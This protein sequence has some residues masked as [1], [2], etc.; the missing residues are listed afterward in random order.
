MSPMACKWARACAPQPMKAMIDE[1]GRA[2]RFAATTLS[3]AVRTRVI[4]PTSST[5]AG[6][7]V[8]L[9]K[10]ETT[11]F[12]GASPRSALRGL[13]VCDFTA[14]RGGS[15]ATAIAASMMRP[16]GTIRRLTGVSQASARARARNSSSMLSTASAVLT[17]RVSRISSDR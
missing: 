13:K 8:S 12:A 4:Q 15:S 6:S 9:L 5:A 10:T 3:P 7:P 11:P 16:S 1:S 14:S 17:P 2:R